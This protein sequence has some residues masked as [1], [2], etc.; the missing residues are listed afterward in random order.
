MDLDNPKSK[1]NLKNLKR[2]IKVERIK[3]DMKMKVT[4]NEEEFKIER[5][6]KDEAMKAASVMVGK[7]NL[8][9]KRFKIKTV[10]KF[11]HASGVM[12]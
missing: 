4:Y 1:V 11:K 5:K 8:S 10:N 7:N 6:T 9:L 12:M 2:A 3:K